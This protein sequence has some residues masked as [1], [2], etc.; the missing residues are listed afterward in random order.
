MKLPSGVHFRA[1]PGYGGKYIAGSD[2]SIWSLTVKRPLRVDAHYRD[3]YLLVHLSDNNRRVSVYVHRLILL[4][5]VGPRP[6]GLACCHKNSDRQD[7]RLSNLCWGD[8]Y[9]QWAD[10]RR[11]QGLTPF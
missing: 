5:F 3:R 1:V 7:N 6:K 9:D 2:G 4:T 11:R 10:R 8:G